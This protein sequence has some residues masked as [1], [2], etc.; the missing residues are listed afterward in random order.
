MAQHVGAE[1]RSERTV[2]EWDFVHRSR[3]DRPGAFRRRTNASIIVKFK[4]KNRLIAVFPR[5]PRKKSASPAARIKD[6]QVS[7]RYRHTAGRQ[8]QIPVHRGNH[9][10]RSSAISSFSYSE[11]STGNLTYNNTFSEIPAFAF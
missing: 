1:D 3:T 11:R 4:P 8:E 2:A 10:M 6:G 7:G 5:Q 9:H